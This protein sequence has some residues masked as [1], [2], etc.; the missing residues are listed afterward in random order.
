MKKIAQ[1]V[2]KWPFSTVVTILIWVV[3][4]IPIPETPLDD[5][6]FIDKWTHIV[7]YGGLSFVIWV[8]YLTRRKNAVIISRLV[9]CGWLAPVMMGGLLELLQAYCTG[10]RR[11]GDWLDF[12]ANA[13]GATLILCGGMLWVWHRAT[14]RKDENGAKSCRNAGRP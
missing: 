14:K 8:E 7:M 6:K 10:G 3:S 12:A 13:A 5:V 11:S 1:F 9:L 2:K 4:L